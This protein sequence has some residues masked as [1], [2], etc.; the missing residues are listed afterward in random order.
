VNHTLLIEQLIRHEDLRLF[1][2]DDATGEPIRKGDTLK[3]NPTIGIGRE[4]SRRGISR[5]EALMM[6]ENDVTE[7]EQQLKQLACWSGLTE[8]RQR[9]LAEMAFQLGHAGL[10]EFRK[11]FAAIESDDFD[12]A[13]DEMRS[14]L[15]ARQTPGRA[16]TLA[17]MMQ[18]DKGD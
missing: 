12:K 15:W 4:L 5:T 8:L 16:D 6:V 2:Y 1:V 13:A 14:S 17:R 9:V 10:L 3:G 11:M 7:V 18:H